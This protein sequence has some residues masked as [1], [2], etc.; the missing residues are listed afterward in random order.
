MRVN[1]S[2]I[3]LITKLH[4]DYYPNYYD[5]IHHLHVAMLN[6]LIFYCV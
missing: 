2:L 4:A 1:K 5:R 6:I 3:I